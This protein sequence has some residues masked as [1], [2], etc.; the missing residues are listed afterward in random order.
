MAAPHEIP[1]ELATST[2]DPETG[3]TS[4]ASLSEKAED[5]PAAAPQPPVGPGPPPNGGT[6]AWLQVLGAFF[7]NFNTWGL[8]N[9]FG[10]FQAEYSRGLLSASTQSAISWIGSLQAFLMLVVGVACGRAID[11]GYFYPDITVGAFCSVFGMMMLSICKTYWQV[12][13]AQGVVVGIGAG[14]TFIPSVAIVGTYFTT[15]RS[16]AM[17][18]GATGSSIGGVIYPVVLRRLIVQIGLTWAIRVV[19]FIMLGTL[20]ISIAVMKPRLPPRKAGPLINTAAL[21]VPVFMVWLLAVFFIFIGLYTPFFYVETYALNLGRIFPS[22]IADKIG[23][24]SVMVPAVL[25]SGI[26]LLGWIAVESQ[27]ALIGVTVLIGLT[28]G[29]IQAVLAANVPFLMPGLSKIG[30]NIGM[31]LFAAGLG[32]L[33]GS[34]VAGAILDAQSKGS[35]LDFK[36]CMAFAG[37]TVFV[38]GLLLV[39][40][41]VMKVGFAIQKA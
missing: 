33:I 37:S 12:I 39:V 18:L 36:G 19:A 25:V 14:M 5:T 1:K 30:T 6:R 15:K 28:S 10:V 13:L 21:R 34:P 4:S 31:T 23:N 40:V 7:L 41:R 22:M 35:V 11:A 16:T 17:G 32:L 20:L 9:A 3:H 24:L 26:V 8:L 29:S 38:G 27:E 2:D